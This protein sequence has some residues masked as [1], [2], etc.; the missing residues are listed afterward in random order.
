LLSTT[1]A[2]RPREAHERTPSAPR[3]RGR[4]C[5][6]ERRANGGEISAAGSRPPRVDARGPTK[7]GRGA[8][9]SIAVVDRCSP[10]TSGL[11]NLRSGCVTI[12]T[13]GHPLP[14]NCRLS[15]FREI[16]LT[17]VR[18]RPSTKRTWRG[19]LSL[20]R[21][22][23]QCSMTFATS[24][25]APGAATTNATTDSPHSSSRQARS[26][27]CHRPRRELVALCSIPFR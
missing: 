16:L 2:T 3:D 26:P 14:A 11:P 20:A 19:F 7:L 1:P 10:A 5:L 13:R 4:R 23:R 21:C 24:K 9:R 17:V 22:C 25:L 12:L 27:V 8:L 15:S 6:R 18:G